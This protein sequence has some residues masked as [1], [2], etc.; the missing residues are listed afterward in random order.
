MQDCR[1]WR[2]ER[3]ASSTPGRTYFPVSVLA[4]RHSF[5]F[6]LLGSCPYRECHCRHNK[7]PASSLDKR[8]SCS[9]SSSTLG[10][11]PPTY[12]TMAGM[13]MA[14][15]DTM[16]RSGPTWIVAMYHIPF[17]MQ[18]GLLHQKFQSK[19]YERHQ[20]LLRMVRMG[21]TPLNIFLAL[22]TMR[23][24]CFRPLTRSGPMNLE[25]GCWFAHLIMKSIEWGLLDTFPGDPTLQ[26]RPQFHLHPLQS[27]SP[28]QISEKPLTKS[29]HET[30]TDHPENDPSNQS[31]KDVL[32][33][34]FHQLTSMRGIGYVW[35][36]KGRKQQEAPT[37]FET[38]QK[39]LMSHAM[40]V[41]ALIVLVMSRDHGS[42][43]EAM[44]SMGI[45]AFPGLGIIAEGLA[46][47]AWGMLCVYG[48]EFAFCFLVFTAHFVNFFS[49]QVVQLPHAFMQWWDLRTFV[50]LFGSP[51][52]ATS[53]AELW[54]SHWHQVYRRSFLAIGAVPASRLATHLDLN[55]KLQR[56][57]GL[58][59]AFAVSAVFHELAISWVAPSTHPSPYHFFHA[60]PASLFYFMMQPVG[61]VI[62]PYVIP[63]IPRW[64]GGGS[65]W[66]LLFTLLTAQPFRDQYAFQSRVIDDTYPPFK[67]WPISG[68]LWP[69]SIMQ[70]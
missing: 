26:L 2:G 18:L 39:F 21:L 16:A 54:A 17:L 65:L 33:W 52:A 6:G 45:P 62:E 40:Q 68:I 5:A 4:Q 14:D 31:F 13:N 66:V 27:S 56:L 70:S 19:A 34:S 36:W 64:L 3:S 50:P 43:T 30:T 41:L 51:L 8:G 53:L 63:H 29:H 24:F 12:I 25:L 48:M 58:F 11:P 69:P 15:G 35:G 55:T 7:S 1:C 32:V 10:R 67:H 49:E 47:F 59:G 9:I 23:K 61:I 46:T 57:C 44:L 38:L 28:Q 20:G 37:L 22:E 42:P 60:F